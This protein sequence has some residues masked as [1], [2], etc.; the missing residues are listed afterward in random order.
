M[1][2]L[3]QEE[4]DDDSDFEINVAI[5]PPIEEA[6][7]GTDC[8]SDASASEV[9]CNPNHLPR[10]ILLSEV[11]P[12]KR[13]DQMPSPD[14]QQ[15]KKKLRKEKVV[16]HR[17]ETK[18]TDSVGDYDM[19]TEEQQVVN[20][21]FLECI[22]HFWTDDWLKFIC[23]QSR[24]YAH[25]KSLQSDVM[26]AD[27]LRVFFGILVLSGYNKLPHRRL[28]WSSKEDAQNLLVTN[29]MRRD[30]FDQIMRCFHFTDNM[31]VNTDRF[32]KVRPIFEHINKVMMHN[33]FQGEFMSVDEV[34]VSYYG[35]HG[36]K[37][38]IRGKP[39]RFGF[40]L[41]AAC[42]SN[43]TLLHVEPY[44]EAHTNIEEHGFGHGPNIVLDMVKKTKLQKGQHVV[45][46]NYFGTVALLK[47][48]ARKGIAGT[49][50]LREDRLSGCPLTA[51]QV[52]NKKV[53]GT[54]VEAYTDCVS[55][56]KWKDNKVVSV[57]SN[58]ARAKPLKYARRWD[59]ITKKHMEIQVPNS[60][61][62]Y[63]KHMG[64]VDL[65]D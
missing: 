19:Q 39:V 18:V 56:V 11:L 49:T 41:W 31:K 45:C 34:M 3:L 40:K 43:S 14:G 26:T 42:D 32:F 37:Q 4:T 44:C 60:I 9:T 52:M 57:A 48:L 10:R 51:R 5:E 13:E 47:E 54:M 38:Y 15:R 64:G 53:R 6:T 46:D 27:N 35:R 8:D 29:S 20:E 30:T 58:K 17:D 33:R 2:E 21:S 50:T 63:N 7:A 36:G 59:R 55:L 23:E 62:L 24:V 1:S 61:S 12:D 22:G 16:W 65:F 25:Q 28:Y